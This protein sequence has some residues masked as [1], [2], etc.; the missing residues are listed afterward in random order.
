MQNTQYFRIPITLNPIIE[1]AEEDAEE[2]ADE[3]TLTAAPIHGYLD[4]WVTVSGMDATAHW[5]VTII[6]GQKITGVN[7]SLG[8]SIG[9]LKHF[10]ALIILLTAFPLQSMILLTIPI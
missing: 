4:F 7:L 1:D 8:W 2:D 6:S 5:E 9:V 10:T 3:Q